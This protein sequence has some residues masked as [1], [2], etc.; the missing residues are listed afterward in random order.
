MMTYMFYQGCQD[1]MQRKK[2]LKGLVCAKVNVRSY[3]Q[4]VGC[5]TAMS[6][7]HSYDDSIHAQT[8]LIY[9]KVKDKFISR[10]SSTSPVVCLSSNTQKVSG[11][12]N[13][14]C[15]M[16]KVDMPASS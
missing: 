14:V 9:S 2:F 15:I 10:D 5:T 4:V 8:K 12:E 1:V 7:T 6:Q 16:G 13:K 11:L 3:A